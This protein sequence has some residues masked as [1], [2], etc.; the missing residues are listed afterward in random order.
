M[1]SSVLF[2]FF[3]IDTGKI[4]MFDKKTNLILLS[5]LIGVSFFIDLID[6]EPF[7]QVSNDGGAAVAL[8]GVAEQVLVEVRHL[9]ELLNE[10]L[11]I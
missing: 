6:V 1:W 9:D 4:D 3:F 2:V 7:R 10:I 11:T 5:A 8:L